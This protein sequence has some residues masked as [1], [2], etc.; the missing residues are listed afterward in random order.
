MDGT[1]G[2]IDC[3]VWLGDEHHLFANEVDVVDPKLLSDVQDG[4]IMNVKIRY[5]HKGA[6]AQ[7]FK[8]TNGFKLKFQEPQRAVTPGQAAVFYRERELVGGGWITL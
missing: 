8:T 2:I 4:E 5:Q 7:V 1:T 3:H 6:P